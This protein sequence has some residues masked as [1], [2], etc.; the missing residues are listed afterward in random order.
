MLSVPTPDF[1]PGG[2]LAFCSLGLDLEP[3]CKLPSVVGLE[4]ITQHSRL[5]IRQL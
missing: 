3:S 5:V 1:V 4:V 2:R